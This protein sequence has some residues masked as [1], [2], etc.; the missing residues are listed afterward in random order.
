[1]FTR[2]NLSSHS[3][4]AGQSREGAFA[5]AQ[6]NSACFTVSWNS[7]TDNS[8]SDNWVSVPSGLVPKSFWKNVQAQVFAAIVA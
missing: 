4:A 3:F 6:G 1:M 2:T 8:G 5:V 7:G